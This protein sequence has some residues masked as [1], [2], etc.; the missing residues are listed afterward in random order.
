MKRHRVKPRPRG[1][2]QPNRQVTAWV[3]P[4]EQAD[5]DRAAASAGLS[6]AAFVRTVLL[7]DGGVAD[8]LRA[9][10]AERDERIASLEEQ[11]AE[12]DRCFGL[13]VAALESQLERARLRCARE[14]DGWE[15]SD[16]VERRWQAHA[17]TYG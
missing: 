1:E 2:P 6:R 9:V 15:L 17:L 7:A 8:V 10:I 14:V 4:E 5:V 13:Q 16:V 12:R 11:L 3:L